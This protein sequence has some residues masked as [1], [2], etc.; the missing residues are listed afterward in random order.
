MPG[1][2]YLTRTSRVAARSCAALT[3]VRRASSSATRIRSVVRSTSTPRPR[4]TALA[5]ASSTV[6]RPAP[7]AAM[8]A[9]RVRLAGQAV[10]ARSI[11]S[12]ASSATR[13]SPTTASRGS[14]TSASTSPHRTALPSTRRSPARPTST[15][16]TT[17]T[18]AIVGPD[19]VE[20]SYWHVAPDRPDG[21]AGRRVRDG[22]RAHRGALRARAL[23]GEARRPLPESAAARRDGPVRRRHPAARRSVVARDGH[24]RRG[25]LRRDAACRSPPVARPSRHAGAR[26]LAPARRARRRRPRWSTAVDFRLTIPPASAFD[27]VWAPGSTQNHVRAPGTYRVVL[28]RSVGD[29]R[30]GRYLVEVNVRDSRGNASSRRVA[31]MP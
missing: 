3:L 8:P 18:V 6:A 29:L 11:R 27:E 10:P 2:D 25:G 20:F 5:A 31:L 26:S 23:L 24:A 7:P 9:R 16:C 21:P 22:D 17:T 15:R 4:I 14:S 13:A 1:H 28:S 30:G 12:A 19:G